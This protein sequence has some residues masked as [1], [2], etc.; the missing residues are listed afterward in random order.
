MNN[1][2][3]VSLIVAIVAA[4]ISLCA[5]LINY[6]GLKQNKRSNNNNVLSKQVDAMMG[7]TQSH[8]SLFIDIIRDDKLAAMVSCTPDVETFRRKQLATI[9]INHCNY[10]FTCMQKALIDGDDS[11]GI[12]NDI[13]DFFRWPIV[14]ERWPEIRSFYSLDFQNFIDKLVVCGRD[15]FPQPASV[16][17]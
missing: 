16:I 8:R 6:L 2:A 11:K 12:K 7:I 13:L 10:I 9:L 3:L 15:D 17:R 4:V 1:I 14:K 5:V